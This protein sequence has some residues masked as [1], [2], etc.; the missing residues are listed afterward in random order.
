[1]ASQL[2]FWLEPYSRCQL[3]A[4]VLV[5]ETSLRREESI[6][7]VGSGWQLTSVSTRTPCQ[8]SGLP[9]RPLG[10]CTLR[11]KWKLAS[12]ETRLT[13]P[14]LKCKSHSPAAWCPSRVGA[15]WRLRTRG[16]R[17]SGTTC[18]SLRIQSG[19]VGRAR[20]LEQEPILLVRHLSQ[21]LVTRERGPA[22]V[23][24]KQV[25]C[26][27]QSLPLREC[28]CLTVHTGLLG[29]ELE[30]APWCPTSATSVW[31][32]G[33]HTSPATT[34]IVRLDLPQVRLWRRFWALFSHYS[35][36][37]VSSLQLPDVRHRNF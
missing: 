7:R 13:F 2:K 21:V 35:P 18:K 20:G 3:Q 34:R 17:W 8:T 12:W 1:M 14:V 27:S 28:P 31:F 4:L 24:D 22:L 32:S 16:A 26:P 10:K 36:A 19:S 30:L 15:G 6:D 11:S 33:Q 23:W 5:L 37:L 25:S 9:R 29:S